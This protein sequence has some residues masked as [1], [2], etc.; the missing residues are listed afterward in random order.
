M[1]SIKKGITSVGDNV[2]KRELSGTIGGNINWYSHFGKHQGDA[3]KVI[4]R[5]TTWSCNSVTVYLLKENQNTNLERYMHS[6]VYCN[7]IYNNQDMEA[8]Q[9]SIKRWMDKEDV[10]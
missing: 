5:N 6:Y 7:I 1:A 2:E 4:N 3:S 9:M 8:T 10:V